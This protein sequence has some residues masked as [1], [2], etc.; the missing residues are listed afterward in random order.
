M[1]DG[2]YRIRQRAHRIQKQHGRP[3][4]SEA[5]RWQRVQREIDSYASSS[6]CASTI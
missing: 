5:E 4:A 2:E 6:A 3:E 1:R